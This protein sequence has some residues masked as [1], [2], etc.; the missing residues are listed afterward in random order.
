MHICG[1]NTIRIMFKPHT[2]IKCCPQPQEPFPQFQG[3][4][5]LELASRKFLFMQLNWFAS[6]KPHSWYLCPLEICGQCISC[7]HLHFAPQL[8]ST[9]PQMTQSGPL[10]Q[11]G[12]CF[13][14]RW[15][16]FSS[17]KCCYHQRKWAFIGSVWFAAIVGSLFGLLG[18]RKWKDAYAVKGMDMNN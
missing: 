3:H 17:P 8:K 12:R 13:S 6:E 14:V 2:F 7:Q 18:I 15:F 10:K 1:L 4:F 5:T 9:C 11:P 16:D